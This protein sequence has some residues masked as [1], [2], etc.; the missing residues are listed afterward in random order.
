[1]ADRFV[2][3]MG[4]I[5][6]DGVLFRSTKSLSETRRVLL[7][8]D[9]FDKAGLPVLAFDDRA[10]VQPNGLTLDLIHFANAHTVSDAMER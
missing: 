10:T 9:Q 3:V 1:M 6:Y 7:A 4:K 2:S 8:D 5:T